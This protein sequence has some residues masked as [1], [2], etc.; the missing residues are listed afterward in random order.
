MPLQSTMLR[1][2]CVHI[3]R[4]ESGVDIAFLAAVWALH[5]AAVWD[6]EVHT[7]MASIC[8]LSWV[9][10]EKALM[11]RYPNR[12]I[13]CVRAS[14]AVTGLRSWSFQPLSSLIWLHLPSQFNILPNCFISLRGKDVFAAVETINSASKP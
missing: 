5:I 10:S 7:V 14:A 9:P 11:T 6:M 4:P 2:D 3:M 12:E 1:V 8:L 13:H